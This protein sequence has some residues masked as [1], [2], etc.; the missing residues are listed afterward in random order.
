MQD[1]TIH[2]C[3]RLL[4]AAAA[5][6]LLAGAGCGDPQPPSPPK[7]SKATTQAADQPPLPVP[8]AGDLNAGFVLAL[9]P[10]TRPELKAGAIEGTD[11]D[12]ALPERLTDAAKGNNVQMTVTEVQYVGDGVLNA[13]ADLTVNGRPI[14]GKTTIPFVAAGGRWKLQKAWVCQ[15]LATANLQSPACPV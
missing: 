10:G 7:T 6:L 4:A 9:D 11:I 8:S 5:A 14:E 3:G 12:P 2:R 13:L 1:A 15:M